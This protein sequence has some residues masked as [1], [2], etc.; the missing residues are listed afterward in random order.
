MVIDYQ[1]ITGELGFTEQDVVSAK[2]QIQQAIRMAEQKFTPGRLA[3]NGLVF[4]KDLQRSESTFNSEGLLSN[5]CVL[6]FLLCQEWLQQLISVKTLNKKHSS[7]G[8]K[9]VVEN[10]SNVYIS[11]GAFIAAALAAGWHCEITNPNS[12]NVYLAMSER[13]LKA[14]WNPNDREQN[15]RV[16]L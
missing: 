14:I 13:S 3:P 15:K 4:G 10:W 2:H 5:A 12:P 9:H 7:Y 8:Y 1:A 6:E 16:I 11:N